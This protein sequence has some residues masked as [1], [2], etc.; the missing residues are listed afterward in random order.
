MKNGKTDK[1]RMVEAER[2]RKTERKKRE[3]EEKR[4]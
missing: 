2:G 1:A 4:F 3:R